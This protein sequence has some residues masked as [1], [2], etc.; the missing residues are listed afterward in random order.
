MEWNTLIQGMLAYFFTTSLINVAVR[1]LRSPAP[2]H[3]LSPFRGL[4]LSAEPKARREAE[5]VRAMCALLT[6]LHP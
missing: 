6:A 4:F 5:C 2:F 1:A 3:P